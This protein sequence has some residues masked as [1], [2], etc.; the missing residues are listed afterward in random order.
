MAYRDFPFPKGTPVFPDRREPFELPFSMACSDRFTGMVQRYLEDYATHFDLRRHIR[1]HTRV[2]RLYQLDPGASAGY[3]MIESAGPGGE[4]REE[5]FDSVCV[6]NGH[7]SD[8]WIP[9]VPGLR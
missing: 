1:F 8:G 7:Y 6:A 9:D 5:V 4:R 2:K 3:W